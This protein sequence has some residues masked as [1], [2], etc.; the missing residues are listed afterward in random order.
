M[1]TRE[2]PGDRGR[3]TATHAL[4]RLG[5]EHRI[6]RVNAGLSLRAVAGP[7]RTSHQQ[8]LRF[9]R[10]SLPNASVADVGAWCGVVGLDLVLRAYPGGDAVRDTGQQ[11]LLGRLRVRIHPDLGWRTEVALAIDG[12]RR[13]WDAV[14]RGSGWA[15]PVEAETILDDLQALERRLNLKRRDGGMDHV[16]LVVADTRRNRRALL[17]A[18]AA[19]PGFD[20]NARHVLRALARGA[21]PDA[22]AVLIL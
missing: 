12:D 21:P 8:V 11:R 5:N 9:E 18:P 17:S 10:G 6:A 3:R 19:F 2:R 4:L 16:I 7:T 22:S 14:I 13:A 15:A 20:R 1:S